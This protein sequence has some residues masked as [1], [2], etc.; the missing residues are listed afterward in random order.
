MRVLFT[1]MNDKQLQLYHS[2]VRAIWRLAF[3]CTALGFTAGVLVGL[4]W[5]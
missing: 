5:C 2:M 1:P 3:T 4:R